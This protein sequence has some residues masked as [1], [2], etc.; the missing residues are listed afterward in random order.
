MCLRGKALVLHIQ[1]SSHVSCSLGVKRNV[2][3]VLAIAENAVDA[4]AFKPH[5]IIR[6]HKGLTVEIGNTDAEGR[7]VLGDALSYAAARHGPHT[8]IDMVRANA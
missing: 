6:S 4:A 2:L 8:V 7:L 3:F 5:N 1:A